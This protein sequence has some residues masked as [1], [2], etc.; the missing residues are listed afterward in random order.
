MNPQVSRLLIANRGEIARRVI[1]TAQ[2]MGIATVAVYSDADR[3]ALHVQEADTAVALGG[4][5]SSESYLRI[6]KLLQAAR[7]T[8]ADA[9]HPGYGF[10]SEN[11]EF[12]QAVIDAGLTWVGP[13]PEAIRALGSK[14]AAK[15][16]AQKHGVPC[17]P[18]YFGTDQ[19]DATFTQHAHRLGFPLMVKAVAG[20]GGR[21]MRLV[22]DMRQLLP[23]LHSAR[24]EALAGFGHGDLLMERALLRPRHIEVQIMADTQG[25]CIHLGERDCSVQR[26]HQKIIEESPSP[27]VDAALRAQLGQAAV[28]LAQSAGYV[29]AGTVEFLLDEARADKPFYL[30]EMN[31][32]L[33]VEHPVTEVLTGLDLVEWQLRIARGEALPLKQADVR[34]HGHAMEVRLCAEDEHFTPQTGTVQAFSAPTALR[35]D[36]AL[37]VGAVV[38]PHY[39]SMLGKLIAHAPTRAEA[40]DR[41]QTGLDQTAV[42]GLPTNR[43]FLAACIQHPIFR[44]GEALIPFLTEQADTVRE[45]LQASADAQTVAA[46]AVLYA[47]HP[48]A[49]HMASPFA[50]P[51]RMGFA[52]QANAWQAAVHELGQGLVRV[53]QGDVTHTALIQHARNTHTKGAHHN[54]VAVTLNGVRWQ[55]QAAHTGGMPLRWHVQVQ[56]THR[57]ELWLSNL[58]HSAPASGP[59]APTATLLRAPF[60]GKLIAL[61][62]R[63]GDSVKQ[64]DA[65][66]VIE[67]MKLEHTLTAV[68]DGVVR[69]VPVS[70]GQQVGPGQVLVQ[71]QEAT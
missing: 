54:T 42:L 61:H 5:L 18:G 33:Q 50:R 35:F 55:V 36:H 66:L 47:Q 20:G 3:N 11:A 59:N 57:T 51:V 1:R 67:S 21:G 43:A 65:L 22:S 63:E 60:N 39:D 40:I 68:R 58:S 9:V 45:R 27:A 38:T 49:Q 70:T 25:H 10:L 52:G 64:G 28:A 71:W 8:G 56:G 6:D 16:L 69:S 53:H 29:G 23:A 7:D 31:T 37:H 32:R 41:L 13:P 24:S 19:S 17:L 15:A 62:V 14:S 26:R 2:R 4:T 12:A 34:L 46:L 44:A 30:M 48:P